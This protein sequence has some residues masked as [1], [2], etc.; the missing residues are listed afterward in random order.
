VAL[1]R[2]AA[3]DPMIVARYA[4]DLPADRWDRILFDR[5]V[6][7]LSIG[8]LLLVAVL[9]PW[10]GL[11][12]AGF[13]TVG[14]LSLNAAVN[15]VGHRFGRQPHPNTARNSQ[16][17]AWLTLG[18]G[19]HNNHHAAPTSAR[20]SHRRSEADPGWWIVWLLERWRL[21]SVRH[22][23]TKLKEAQAA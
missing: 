11:L 23:G 22:R 18:E 7:G 17:L 19:L 6:L 16:W 15:A 1:Y 14:Y 8:I 4:R 13:H 20:F 10:M 12:A 9:G 2:R 3:A 5:A 21:T